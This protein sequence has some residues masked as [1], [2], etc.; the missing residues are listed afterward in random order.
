MLFAHNADFAVYTPGVHWEIETVN[1]RKCAEYVLKTYDKDGDFLN[2]I[3]L[4]PEQH[5]NLTV[6]I[7][8]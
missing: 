4:T 1:H 3:P 2:S 5:E 8:K 6:E 7:W